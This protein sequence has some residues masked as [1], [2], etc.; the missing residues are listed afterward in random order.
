MAIQVRAIEGHDFERVH[1]FQ[2]E[3]LDS[4]GFHEFTKRVAINP[5]LYLVAVDGSELVG[6]CFGHPSNRDISVMNLQGIAVNLDDTKGYARIGIG[7]TLMRAFESAVKKRGYK[8][9]GVGSADDPKVEAFYLKNRFKPIE[10]VA[11]DLHYEEIERVKV[12]NFETGNVVREDLC[13]KHS[14]RE[15][16]FIFEKVVD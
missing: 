2:C 11:K 7:S 15:V 3:Y 14:P 4:E 16:I 5:D 6:I 12:E 10:L 8:K 9:I 1:A 13:R